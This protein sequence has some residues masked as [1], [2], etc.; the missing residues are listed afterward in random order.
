MIR[1][2][3]NF[4]IEYSVRPFWDKME[5]MKL[6]MITVLF[7]SL[8]NIN[9]VIATPA[10]LCMDS[11]NGLN[12]YVKGDATGFE[13][14]GETH[15]TFEDYCANSPT[16]D[17]EYNL[18]EQYCKGDY[19][20]ADF[21]TCPNGCEDGAC[22][23]EVVEYTCS[24]S[25]ETPTNNGYDYFTKG[26]VIGTDM[27]D[28]SI[29]SKVDTCESAITLREYYCNQG[30]VM[31]YGTGC[32]DGCNEG[33]CVVEDEPSCISEGEYTNGATSPTY[34]NSC[35]AGLVGFDT[36]QN[37]N[38]TQDI[39]PAIVGRGMLCYD[40]AKGE[41]VCS[42]QGTRSEGWYYPNNGGLLK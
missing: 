1:N 17:T 40:P 38:T 23:D 5:K 19:V 6:L 39:A 24:D 25:D 21:Y 14:D 26:V 34:Q 3:L 4:Y 11:D 42:A 12:Y 18:V 16:Y 13:V 15:S 22:I 28:L 30:F 29:I 8:F 33:V 9:S 27:N 2:Y 41:P 20:Y 35:C 31:S 7:V 10:A 32:K 36:T 37:F